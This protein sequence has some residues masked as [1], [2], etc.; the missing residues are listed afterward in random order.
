MDKKAKDRISILIVLISFALVWVLVNAQQLIFGAVAYL[1]IG[2]FCLFL[3]S[4]WGKFGK[5]SDLEGIDDKWGINALIGLG[6]GVGTIILGQVFSFIGA[7]GIPPVQSIA[8]II[9]RFLIV[10]PVASTFEPVFFNDFFHD[11]LESKIGLPRIVA[12]LITASAFAL[13]HLIAYGGS[14]SASGGSFFTAGLMGFVFGLVTEWR[15]SLAVNMVYH[16]VLNTWIGFVK[17]A[18][19]I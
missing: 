9:G 15:N 11:L 13:F 17:L 7:I 1:I 5:I 8:G 12:M 14:L 18:V 2:S 4:Q 16:G 19:I 10:V 3:Y 6:L